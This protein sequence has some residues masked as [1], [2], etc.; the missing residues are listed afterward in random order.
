MSA[1]PRKADIA[2]GDWNVR[3][4][5]KRTSGHSLN[6]LLGPLLKL[7]RHIEAEGFG[8]L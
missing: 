6:Y 5:Q 1:I 3:F 8:G 2:E 7:Q 4:V